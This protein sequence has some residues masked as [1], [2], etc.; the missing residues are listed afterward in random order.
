MGSSGTVHGRSLPFRLAVLA[1]NMTAGIMV[2]STTVTVSSPK[3]LG[4]KM[5]TSNSISAKEVPRG[6]YRPHI[7]LMRP[8]MRCW[9]MKA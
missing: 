8:Q 6:A 7:S 4:V 2:G 3:V 9:Y 1:M 5:G